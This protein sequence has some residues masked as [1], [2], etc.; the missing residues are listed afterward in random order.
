MDCEKAGK[1]FIVYIDELITT[2]KPSSRLGSAQSSVKI[3]WHHNQIEEYISRLDKLQGSLL[4]ATT[5]SLRTRDTGNHHEILEHLKSI[6][7]GNGSSQQN[8]DELIRALRLLHDLVQQ[9]SGPKLDMLQ[10]QMDSC[11]ED[12]QKIRSWVTNTREGEIL[13]WLD[14]RQRTWRFEEVEKAHQTTF[15]WIFRKTHANTTWHDFGAHLSGAEVSLPYFI[16]GKAGSGKSTLMKY[17]VS[18]PQTKAGLQK[19]AGQYKLLSLHFFFWNVG[20]QLQKSHTGMLRSLLHSVLTQYH[21]LIPAVFP[22]LYAD[23]IPISD[24]EPPS[25]IELKGAF[26]RLKIRSA[27]FLRIC[28]FIDGADEFEGDHRDMSTFLCSIASS[29]I[30]VVVSSRPINACLNVFKH[31]PTLR[32]QDLT[33]DD[34]SVFI[35]DRLSLHSMMAE[36]QAESPEKAA[37]LKAEIREKA[38]GVFLWVRLVTGLLLRGL[39]D[40][41]DLDDLLPKLRALPSDLRELYTRMMQKMPSDYQVQASQMF[42]I[43]EWWRLR[44]N[45]EPLELLLLSF[46]IQQP[47]TALNPRTDAWNTQMKKRYSERIE[48]R[49]RSRCCGLLEVRGIPTASMFWPPTPV[50]AYLHRSVAEFVTSQDVWDD[51]LSLTNDTKFSPGTHIACGILSILKTSYP[52]PGESKHLRAPRISDRTDYSERILDLAM[53]VCRQNADIEDSLMLKYMEAVDKTMASTSQDL[54]RNLIDRQDCQLS[55]HWSVRMAPSCLELEIQHLANHVPLRDQ[56]NIRS[57]AAYNGI[58]TYLKAVNRSSKLVDVELLILFALG[59]WADGKFSFPDRRET[60]WFLLQILGDR[61]ELGI[62]SPIGNNTLWE[63][64]V[65]VA[66]DFFNG[67]RRRRPLNVPFTETFKMSGQHIGPSTFDTLDTGESW[68]SSVHSQRELLQYHLYA[69]TLELDP[70]AQLHY[71]ELALRRNEITLTGGKRRKW[72]SGADWH[73]EIFEEHVLT[74]GREYDGLVEPYDTLIHPGAER[75]SRGVDVSNTQ[76]A[77]DIL[78]L[79]LS[80]TD[81]PRELL[82]KAIK[83]PKRSTFKPLAILQKALAQGRDKTQGWSLQSEYQFLYQLVELSEACQSAGEYPNPFEPRNIWLTQ[84]HSSIS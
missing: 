11:M 57:F 50:V 73:H 9:Q 36:L 60:L 35:R 70:P 37:T 74:P 33:Q 53:D 65:V 21:D 41:D 14:F 42:Q 16:N 24:D 27:T 23:G 22:T 2:S 47:S 5:L 66:Y 55:A 7:A 6:E 71:E 39:E 49:V 45:D 29:A 38:E 44:G 56:A 79:F 51:M 40:G 15:D 25:Y 69:G 68:Q 10:K 13:R 62:E 81:K 20:T 76:Q 31:C 52:P 84:S 30:K 46:A 63:H 78:R 48:A 77:A 43:F 4:L 72:E 61:S 75:E 83:T 80:I 28:I 34:M 54:A 8:D 64:A 59:S 12:I 17:I 19:W 18:H 3:K 58:L 82:N 67:P 32:L 26:E 1:E